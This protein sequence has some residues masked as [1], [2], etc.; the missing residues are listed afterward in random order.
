MQI[1]Y[2]I[3]MAINQDK[4]ENE[5]IS[6]TRIQQKCNTSYDKLLKYLEEMEQKG[7]IQMNHDIEITQRGQKFFNDYARVNNLIEEITSRLV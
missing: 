4:L 1:Y 7:L 3:M 6:K 5:K 2:E